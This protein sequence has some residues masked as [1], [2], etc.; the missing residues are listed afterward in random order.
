MSKIAIL[1]NMMDFDPGYS[2]TGIIQDQVRMLKRYGH[3]VHLYVNSQFNQ[4]YLD[5]FKNITVHQSIPFAHL[6][7]YQSFKDMTEYHKKTVDDF[8]EIL[9]KDLADCEIVYTHDFIFTGWFLP[10]GM[11]CIKASRNLPNT[12]W[13]HW[14]HSVP[15]GMRDWWNA[16]G[17]GKQHKIIF[18]NPSD[19]IRV[20]EQFRGT[21][22]NVRIIP[23]IKDLRTWMDFHKDTCRLIDMMPSIM[24]AKIMQ[25]LPAGSDR[26]SAK[27]VAQVIKIFGHIKEQGNTVC[28]LMANQ[29]ATGR[30]RK[31][32]LEPYE[33]L[34][35]SV[36]LVPKKDFAFTSDM[37][38]D[39]ANGMPKHMVRELFQCSN[40]FIF[41]TREESF[42]LVVPEAALSGGVL[43]VLNESLKSQV[44]ISGNHAL[45]FRFGSFTDPININDEAGYYRDVAHIVLGRMLQDES[46][47]LKTFFKNSNNMDELYTKYYAPIMGESKL[48]VS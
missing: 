14:A 20:A 15:T 1:T 28:L 7:D 19:R 9:V 41:P 5:Y 21:I 40:L 2:L 46:I 17:F 26:L 18:P 45:Y 33:T 42:G 16:P 38:D 8:C 39:W 35:K 31:E 34:A 37:H 22:E 11:G 23:H 44:A 27:G 30:V 47:M 32:C 25:V 4:K 13:M 43:P 3:D 10:Y 36:G 29:W 24:S 12:R 48:W 6:T